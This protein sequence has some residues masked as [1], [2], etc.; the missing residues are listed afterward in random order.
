[1]LSPPTADQLHL[2]S[3][4][5]MKSVTANGADICLASKLSRALLLSTFRRSNLA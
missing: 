5:S 2:G 4:L 1:M 3:S